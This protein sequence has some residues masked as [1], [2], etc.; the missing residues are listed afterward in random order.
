MARSRL[1]ATSASGRNFNLVAQAGV[2]WRN[3]S[4]AQSQLTTTSASWIEAILLPQPPEL[5]CSGAILAHC[6]LHLR[7]SR[8][9]PTSTSR[10][11]GTTDACHH[12]WLIFCIFSRDEVSPNRQTTCQVPLM[13]RQQCRGQGPKRDRQTLTVMRSRA[14]WEAKAGGSRGQEFK[15]RLAN[16]LLRRL[17]QENCLNPGG[18]GCVEMWFHHVGLAS[19]ELLTSGDPP[20]WPPKTGFHQVGQAGLELLTS[21]SCTVAQAVVQWRISAHCNLGLLGSSNSVASASQVAGTTGMHR[22]V[23]LIFLSEG[24]GEVAHAYN[25]RIL[26]GQDGVLLVAQAGVQWHVF[27]SPQPPPPEFK[28]VSCLSILRSWDHRHMPPRPANS[29]TFSRDT[30]S[31]YWVLLSPRL[32]YSSKITPY[33]SLDLQG[34]MMQ[35]HHTAQAGLKLPGSGD[36]AT[37]LELQA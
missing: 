12:T 26:G 23:Q 28:Q 19:L 10:I 15:T 13:H 37:V 17:R 16:M 4:S 3:L 5:E 32:E 1:T 11:A 7:G 30:V 29:C 36:P 8:D 2:Q 25:S 22:H 6:N 31:S 21:E 27:S 24:P 9:S 35:Y 34:S 33:C 18:K 14:L 20:T